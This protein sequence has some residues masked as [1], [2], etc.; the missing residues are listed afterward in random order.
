MPKIPRC[1][2]AAAPILAGVLVC[3]AGLAHAGVSLPSANLSVEADLYNQQI[4]SNSF[5]DICCSLSDNS[6]DAATSSFQGS[7]SDPTL[8]ASFTGGGGQATVQLQYQF[9]I[10][11]PARSAQVDIFASGSISDE[12][13]DATPELLNANAFAGF[14]VGGGTNQGFVWF[15]GSCAGTGNLSTVGQGFAAPC[16]GVYDQAVGSIAYVDVQGVYTLPTNQQDFLSMN[17]SVQGV[18]GGEDVTFISQL[19]PILAID[20]STPDAGAYSIEFPAMGGA[21]PSPEPMTWALMLIGL[22]G[23]GAVLRARRASA[24]SRETTSPA[25]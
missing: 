12:G 16:G 25:R 24:N 22:A 23:V 13:F 5:S 2:C 19:D 9:E 10:T 7:L 20:P 14:G 21:A 4:T 15:V 11:G 3:V 6:G 18:G 1:G 8:E 17:V